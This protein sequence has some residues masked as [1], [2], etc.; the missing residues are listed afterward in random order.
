MKQETQKNSKGFTLLEMLVVVL[1][2]GILAAIAL[3]QYEMAV[4]K[5][6]VATILPLMRRWKDALYEYKLQH[7][8]YL[9][10]I[11]ADV[12]GDILGVTWPSDW[13]KTGTNKSCSI[14]GGCYNDYWSCFANEEQS[15]MTYCVHEISGDDDVFRIFMFQHD[16]HW[17]EDSRDMMICEG[18]G[19]KGNKVCKAL[20]GKLLEDVTV[21]NGISYKLN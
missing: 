18:V 20:G 3:P 10:D 12:F 7:G 4:T 8:D 5:A 13:K 6:K 1:I 14:A 11:N 9:E 15:G 17:Y 19:T 21:W 2:I 16:D